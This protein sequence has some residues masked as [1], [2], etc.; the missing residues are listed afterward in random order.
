MNITLTNLSKSGLLGF[1]AS[2]GD[3]LMNC[4]AVANRTQVV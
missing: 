2:S 3:R 4:N 1:A